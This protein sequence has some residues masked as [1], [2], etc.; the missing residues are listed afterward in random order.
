[1]GGKDLDVLLQKQDDN[2]AAVVNQKLQPAGVE[3]SCQGDERE[4]ETDMTA[5]VGHFL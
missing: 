4:H 2:M 5:L 3:L 1:M